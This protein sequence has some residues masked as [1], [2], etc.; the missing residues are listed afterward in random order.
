MPWDNG[1]GGRSWQEAERDQNVAVPGL[2]EE[3]NNNQC[4]VLA[5]AKARVNKMGVLG[6]FPLKTGAHTSSCMLAGTTAHVLA[7]VLVVARELG[8]G[9][10]EM[11]DPAASRAVPTVTVDPGPK[12]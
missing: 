1:V 11:M 4:L 7:A 8:H 12:P 5:A 9:R 3:G 2:I 6:I 10:E